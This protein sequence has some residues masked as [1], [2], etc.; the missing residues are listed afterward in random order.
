MK[1]A[2]VLG[3]WLGMLDA[4]RGKQVAGNGRHGCS[5]RSNAPWRSDISWML[6]VKS[7]PWNYSTF[8]QISTWNI[9]WVA[10]L[11]HT[12]HTTSSRAARQR[13]SVQWVARNC[14]FPG[15]KG[16]TL[17]EILCSDVSE[18]PQVEDNSRKA[19][20]ISCWHFRIKSAKICRANQKSVTQK[21]W[22]R[23]EN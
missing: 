15:H 7:S 18:H 13:K 22:R 3:V 10:M 20:W 9:F 12:A 2:R 4:S 21:C 16:L 17:T 19:S 8:S 11:T 14:L 6:I 23:E 5:S 1:T